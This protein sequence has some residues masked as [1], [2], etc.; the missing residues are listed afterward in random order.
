M[1]GVRMT[2]GLEGRFE[3]FR[4]K[5]GLNS[6]QALRMLLEMGLS[7]SDKLDEDWLRAALHEGMSTGT[8]EIQETVGRALRE[9][10]K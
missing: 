5:A 8:R 2:E 6:S 10:L 9:K 7:K 3:A 4:E 1:L